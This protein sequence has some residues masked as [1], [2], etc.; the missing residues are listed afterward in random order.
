[1]LIPHVVNNYSESGD[2]P[3]PALTWQEVGVLTD[4]I[5][6]FIIDSINPKTTYFI[7]SIVIT[8]SPAWAL[9]WYP[10]EISR[11]KDNNGYSSTSESVTKKDKRAELLK[12]E[13]WF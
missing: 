7:T 9:W 13:R 12:D 10:T 1:M 11:P 3:L 5:M 4:I 2:E 6:N 8:Q